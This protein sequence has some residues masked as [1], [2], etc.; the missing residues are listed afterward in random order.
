MIE[1]TAT[2]PI[3]AAVALPPNVV[4]HGGKK[5][6]HDAKGSLVPVESVKTADL[7][8]DE[9]VRKVVGYAEPLSAQIARFKQHS[10]DDVDTLVEIL[11]LTYGAKLGGR[12]GNITLYT[13][14]GLMKVQVAVADNVVFGPELQVAKQLFDECVLEWS[15]GSHDHI[16]ALIGKAFNTDKEGLV[17]RAELLSLTRVE[18]DDPRWNQAVAAIRDAQRVIG[19]KRYIRVYTRPNVDA[20]WVATTLDVAGA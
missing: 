19:S 4:E 9:I 6:L 16:R 11:T 10:F 17:N 14:D 3:E 7:M 18:I 13:F 2:N 20:A 8:M 15:L 5:Y 12:K 1:Q